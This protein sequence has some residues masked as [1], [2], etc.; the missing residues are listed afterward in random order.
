MT[1]QA[2]PARASPARIVTAPSTGAI[3]ENGQPI[4]LTDVPV[5]SIDEF[6]RRVIGAVADGG[7]M[8]SFFGSR[9][10]GHVVLTAVVGHG[11]TGRLEVLSSAVDREYESITPQCP[12]AHMFEREIFELWGVQPAGHPW[13][14]PVRDPIAYGDFFEVHGDEVHEVAVGPVHAGVIEPG[15]FRFQCHGEQVIHLEI[16]LGYQHRGIEKVL[17]GGPHKSTL[18]QIETIAGDTCVGHATAYCRA[19]EGLS[20]TEVS[21]RAHAIRAIALELERIANHVGDLGALAGDVGF[22]PTASYC[23]RIRGDA[24]NLT[25]SVC[26]NRI[27]RGWVRPGGVYYDIDGDIAMTLRSGLSKLLG[28]FDSG[29]G[30]LWREPTVMSRF[31]GTGAV[32]SVDAES[33]GLVGVAARACGIA[34]DVRTEFPYPPFRSMT[35]DIATVLSGDVY[36]R[37]YVRWLEVGR[38]A[39]HVQELLDTLPGGPAKVDPRPLRADS[40]VVSLVEGWRGEVCHTAITDGDGRLAVYKVVDLSFHNW[41]GLAIALRGQ[42]ISDFP[43]CNKSFNLSYC[44]HDL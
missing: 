1:G 37:A 12:Q 10:Q 17:E 34:R 22:L 5:L 24:L 33:L 43:L 19:L 21:P 44:G 36:A 35:P 40:L 13:L 42:A 20:R 38:S 6:R 23:G 9:E 16:A 4:P 32:S 30:L 3:V 2:I 28:D 7:H 25:T 14:K 11:S 27:G 41:T 26:G 8:K 39:A 18:F 29:A 31:E 15:H